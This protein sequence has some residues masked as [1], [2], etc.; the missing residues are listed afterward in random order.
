MTANNGLEP[1]AVY[2]VHPEQQE[3]LYPELAPVSV[4]E[5]DIVV[6]PPVHHSHNSN[7]YSQPLNQ[8][9]GSRVLILNEEK[10]KSTSS[11]MGRAMRCLC[12]GSSKLVL[13][14]GAALCFILAMIILVSSKP[15]TY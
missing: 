8:S 1:Q 13:L 2:V 14:S 4:V 7:H 15:K 9:N 6:E 10:E 3:R 5:R 12:V 11:C